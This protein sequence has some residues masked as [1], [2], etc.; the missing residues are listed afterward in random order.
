MLE[1]T[2]YEAG[3]R[4]HALF[5]EFSS[6][7]DENAF[8]EIFADRA[9]WGLLPALLPV[10]TTKNR[11]PQLFK[12]V[13]EWRR[14]SAERGISLVQAAIEY[15]KDFSGWTDQ[16]VRNY[17]ESINDI[18]FN[19][20]H[21]LETVGYDRAKD[22]PNLLI[23]GRAWNRHLQSGRVLENP[24]IRHIITHA[25]SANAKLPGTKI[26]PG[27]MGT[28]GYLYSAIDAVREAHGFRYEKVIESLIAAAGLGAIAFTGAQASGNSGYIGESGICCAMDSGGIVWMAGGDGWQVE[29]AASMA[30]QAS[31]EIPCDPILCGKEFPCI[32][33]TIRAAVT[34]PLYADLA[35]SGIDPLIPYHEVLLG[36]EKS[37]KNSSESILH[38]GIN[39]APCAKRC[40]ACFQS[41]QMSH[42]FILPFANIG[43]FNFTHFQLSEVREYL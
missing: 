39:A 36:I 33:C 38:C 15:E 9:E 25:M 24:I 18:L 41:E 4:R 27:P 2:C 28:G 1:A 34:A 35:L 21:S 31:L 32:T 40:Q 20:I 10:V 11:K 13:Q 12:N 16:R 26:V 42:K 23:Y 43:S 17:F 6:M 30:L 22:T 14:V 8:A 7:S 29:N 37:W 5:M 19:Q 3:E